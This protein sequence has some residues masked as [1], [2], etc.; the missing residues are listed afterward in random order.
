MNAN[1]YQHF[2]SDEHPF[3]DT[4]ED[5]IEQVTMQYAPLLTNFLDPRQAYILETLVRQNTD[6]KFQFFGGYEAAERTRCLIFPDYYQPEQDE[7]D[8]ALYTIN[9]PKKF[10]TLSHGKILGTLIGSGVKRE[11]FGDII[12]D[13]ESWQVFVAKEVSSFV[14]LQVTKMGNVSVRLEK[15]DYTQIIMPKDGWTPERET[16]SS[17]RLD[18][19]ISS[20]FNISRQRS[21]QLIES[22]KI[23]INWTENTR[24]DFMLDLLDIVSIRGFGRLQIQGIEGTTKKEK[25]R[26]LLGVLRK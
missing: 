23:K 18:T 25:I 17:L 19:V 11:F 7:F 2:R 8:I 24:P 13:G 5:W 15:S 20:V 10:T 4:V 6:L 9:Y 21:K 26:L 12:S 3:I 22:G 16:V 1:V 14:E